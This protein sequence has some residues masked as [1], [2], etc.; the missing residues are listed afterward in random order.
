MTWLSFDD[1]YTRE[2]VWDDIPHDSRWLYHAIVEKCCAERRYDGRLRHAA[3]MRC[4]D[5]TEPER[6]AK[7]LI[8]AGLLADLGAELQVIDIDS[9]LPPEGQRPENVLQR[10]RANQRA[11]RQ[12]KCE[13]GEHDR[14]CPADTCPDRA[15]RVIARVAGN[16]GSGRVGSGNP[17]PHLREE[18]LGLPG[19]LDPWAGGRSD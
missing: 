15:A 6:S 7:E 4:S 19:D 10:K 13:R 8:D 14:H 9:F 18:D 3:A 12:R 5:V 1:G 16:P 17:N 2:K 11:Y